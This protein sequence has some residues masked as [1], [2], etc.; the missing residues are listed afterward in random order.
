MTT[1][2]A[3]ETGLEAFTCPHC[4]VLARQ[5]HHANNPRLE[6]PAYFNPNDPIRTSICEYCDDFCIWH[7]DKM[8][9]PNR[10]YAPPPNP[11]LPDEVRDDYEEAAS[12]SSRSPRGAAAL[13]R[14]AIQ[15]LCIELGG[16]GDNLNE[17]IGA[18]VK[19]GLPVRIQQSLDITRV[20]GN[21]ALHPGQIDVDDADVVGNLFALLNLITDYMKSMPTK[22]D[23]LYEELPDGA[24]EAIK[25]RDNNP[26][27]TS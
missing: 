5:H 19:N 4:G 26:T 3:P 21:N 14:L 8:I 13:L 25:R 20:I 7:F 24:K 1:F 6:G 16:K 2:V 18:L 27:Q 10:G 17:D 11:D 15:K 22:I 23:N 12:I 9:Y